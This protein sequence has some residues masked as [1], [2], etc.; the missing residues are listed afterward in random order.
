VVGIVD[1]LTGANYMFLRSPPAEWT[2]L[3]VLGPWPWY[4][5]SAAGVALVLLTVLDAPFWSR[6]RRAPVPASPAPLRPATPNP[7]GT[8]GRPARDVVAP[9][10]RLSGRGRLER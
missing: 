4:V 3:R 6:R 8:T 2:L 7:R 1:A 9:D 5:V 10:A